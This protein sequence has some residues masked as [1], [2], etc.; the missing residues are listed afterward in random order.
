MDPLG[1]PG[2]LGVLFS[3]LLGSRLVSGF[4][5]RDLQLGLGLRVKESGPGV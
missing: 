2:S 3:M 4:G 5:L 1:C